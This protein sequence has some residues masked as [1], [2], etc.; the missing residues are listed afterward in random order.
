MFESGVMQAR[1]N[2]GPAEGKSGK[3]MAEE[4][5]QTQVMERGLEEE[6]APETE[7]PVATKPS[8]EQWLPTKEEAETPSL[9]P[10]IMPPLTSKLPT[11][12][13][14]KITEV[15][16]E[17]P[18]TIQK[19]IPET[20]VEAVS[21]TAPV[22]TMEAGTEAA[23]MREDKAPAVVAEGGVPTETTPAEAPTEVP[24]EAPPEKVITE[25][26][27]EAEAEGKRVEAEA[28]AEAVPEGTGEKSPSSPG[29]DPAFQAV[30]KR[31]KGVAARLGHNT[32]AQARAAEAQAAAPGP[33]NELTS[34]AA[35]NQVNEMDAEQPKPFDRTAFKA[36]LMEKIASI[37]PK[38]LEE[39][40]KFKNSG[41]VASIKG[42][43][44]DKVSAGKEKAQGGIAEKTEQTPDTSGIQPKPVTP[45]APV[46]VGPPAPDVGSSRAAP[47]AKTESEVSLQENSLKL[48]QQMADADVTEEQLEK[49][50]EP[51]FQT[52]LETKESAQSDAVEAP[53]AYRLDEQGVLSQAQSQAV[54]STNTDLNVM[55]NVRG[56]Q[57][58]GVMGH[59]EETKTEDTQ[60][61]AEVANHIDGIYK[62]TK[63]RVEARLA[64]LDED[65]NK[66][67][68][69]GAADAKQAFE[70]YVEQ[71]M[72][73]YK[74]RRYSGVIGKGRWLKDKA[75]G[76]PSEVNVFYLEGRDLYI[77]KMDAVLDSIATIVEIGLTEAKDEIAKGRQEI[78]N[79]IDN[80]LPLSLK[81]VGQQAAQDIQG[82][83]DKLEQ[84]VDD[85]QGQLVDSLAQKYADNLQQIDSRIEE[86]KAANRGFVDAAFDAIAGVI[87]TIIKLKNMLLNVLSQAANAIGLIIKDPIGFLGNLV[88]G[89]MQGLEGFMSKLGEYLKKGLMEWLFGALAK[90]GI[91]IPESFDLKGILSLVL[92]VLGLT[93]ANIRARAVAIVGEPI[94]QALEQTAGI[95]KTLITEGPAGLWN[96]IKDKVGDL[97]TMVIE[98]IKSFVMEKVIVAGITWIISM[99][100]PASAFI[101]AC[102]AIY[103]IVMFFVTRGSQIM[104]LVNAVINS[105]G[106]IASGSIS[107]MASAVE[108]ALAR[109]I[110]VVIAFLASLL[111]VGGISEKIRSIIQKIQAPINNAIDWVIHKAVKLVK[112]AG[113]LL[114]IGKKKEQAP[115]TDDPEHDAKVVAGLAS[116]DQEEQKHL[117]ENKMSEEDAEKVA[118]TVKAKHPVFKS[119]TVVDGGDTWDYDYIASPVKKKK[120]VKQKIGKMDLDTLK[121]KCYKKY[122][123]EAYKDQVD[124]QEKG[125]RKLDVEKWEKNREDY[126][127]FGRSGEGAAKQAALRKKK[128]EDLKKQG[129]TPKEIDDVMEQIAALHNPDQVAGGEP[130]VE[131]LGDKRINSSI[132][133]QWRWR[134]KEIKPRIDKK[135]IPQKQKG[136]V[137]MNVKLKTIQM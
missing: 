84:R 116:I 73:A 60:E 128:R 57:L 104:A 17:A 66:A 117:E 111:G 41:K 34:G 94:V 90:A 126:K 105:I 52:A 87:K 18:P 98:G 6:I 71:R 115:E 123:F 59:Q 22:E 110:P 7:Y 54:T 75:F 51:E 39:A 132:G 26:G 58:N 80:E 45:L 28:P 53:T 69:S 38:T 35:A 129:K 109:A 130:L 114:G 83:F 127:N 102:K 40:D 120:G 113:K 15:K 100:N 4:T 37:T 95:F 31:A 63:E 10:Q 107:V 3:G 9:E 67:F 133:S 136:K 27:A 82:E 43:V 16:R 119:I 97:K 32:P 103:D 86:M 50:N 61:R 55:H 121:F 19:V 46:D 24:A 30:V 99:L 93:Y 36:A 108:N 91:Q 64:L 21:P 79:Y 49:S 137:K 5:E 124:D 12:S 89:V 85:K 92:Q 8:P 65:V 131:E 78:Q 125:L 23:A 1:R 2:R 42:E 118:A 96:W 48:D 29:E 20:P 112:A 122:K 135:E 76:M 25:A 44:S 72:D 101:K 70:D 68:D 13:K 47:K 11:P 106:A 74:D 33:P 88:S 62:S 81:D 77:A 14:S 134:V 56:E